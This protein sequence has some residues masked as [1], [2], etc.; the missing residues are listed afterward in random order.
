MTFNLKILRKET[1][2]LRQW[3]ESVSFEYIFSVCVKFRTRSNLLGWWRGRRKPLL[4]LSQERKDFLA[5]S[6]KGIRNI[7]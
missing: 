5:L 4:L 6:Y 2:S 7:S 3:R 1:D